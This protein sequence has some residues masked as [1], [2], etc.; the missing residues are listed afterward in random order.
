MKDSPFLF[1]KGNGGRAASFINKSYWRVQ[2][3]LFSKA[4]AVLD[5]R[6]ITKSDSKA[7][8]TAGLPKASRC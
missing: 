3:S 4:V 7:A 8:S 6:E 2:R 1:Y 5:V